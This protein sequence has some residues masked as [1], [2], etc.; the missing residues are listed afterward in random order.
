MSEARIDKAVLLLLPALRYRDDVVGARLEPVP[1][2]PD[3][4][5]ASQSVRERCRV[6]PRSKPDWKRN[7]EHFLTVRKHL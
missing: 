5:A 6:V 7:R 3:H 1:R 2:Q 4:A